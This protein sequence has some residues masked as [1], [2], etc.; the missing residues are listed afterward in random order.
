MAR[1]YSEDLRIRII[2]AYEQGLGTIRE[3]AKQFQVGKTFVGKLLQRWQ[4]K[5]IVS[6]LPQG[7]GIKSKLEPVH[8][9]Q[10]QKMVEAKNDITL[11][12]LKEGLQQATGLEISVPTIHRSLVKLG[13]S[14][15]KKHFTTLSK[16][17][18]K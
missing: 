17:Q 10:L 4:E 2:T 3:I 9:Q 13:L 11:A 14:R 15:K 8:L 5:G 12:E 6:P 7:G 18:K 16:N 1:A